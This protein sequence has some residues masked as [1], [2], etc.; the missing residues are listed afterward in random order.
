MRFALKSRRSPL[1]PIAPDAPKALR[2]E[3]ER[4]LDVVK[5][6][7]H[8]PRLIDEST[9]SEGM[10]FMLNIHFIDVII[11]AEPLDHFYRMEAVDS[12]KRIEEEIV[13]A[14]GDASKK[15]PSGQDLRFYLERLSRNLGPLSSCDP[16]LINHFVNSYNH[17]RHEPEPVFSQKDYRNHVQLLNQLLQ[18]IRSTQQPQ[19]NNSRGSH[20]N[21]GSNVSIN[22]QPTSRKVSSHQE[23]HSET[24]V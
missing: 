18:S 17:A 23:S 15:K 11:P 4:R 21:K 24:R 6:I 2:K 12:L 5:D 9:L 16:D 22:G 1:V 10:F 8:E 13:L 19:Q 14:T 20:L 3:I 7:R